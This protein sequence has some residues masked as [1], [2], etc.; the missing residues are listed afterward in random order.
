PHQQP[1]GAPPKRR[2]PPAPPPPP[3]PPEKELPQTAS[4]T[5]TTALQ[6]P[7]RREAAAAPPSPPP[8]PLG[9]ASGTAT[10]SGPLTLSV[11]DFPYA[12]YIRQI[13]GKIQEK[14]VGRAIPGQQPAIVF[15]IRR[16]GRLNVATID[17]SS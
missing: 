16:D 12:W 1:P 9:A 14:W 10:G 11:S 2:L 17:P 6:T 3:R 13:Q 15:E 7:I 4:T 5:P 8:A